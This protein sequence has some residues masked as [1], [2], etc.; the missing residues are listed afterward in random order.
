MHTAKLLV[1]IAL[2]LTATLAQAAGFASSTCLRTPTLRALR[3]VGPV[4]D[5]K[6]RAQYRFDSRHPSEK[7]GVQSLPPART[8][9]AA[10]AMRPLASRFC[11]NDA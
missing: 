9:A 8:G 3:N 2:C 5:T 7:A 4:S 1:T 11:G 10:E 6:L